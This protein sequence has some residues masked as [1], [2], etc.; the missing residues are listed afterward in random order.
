M[1]LPAVRH[2]LFS[3]LLQFKQNIFPSTKVKSSLN[4]LTFISDGKPQEIKDTTDSFR[5]SLAI[6]E[7]ER[8][9]P[10][11]VNITVVDLLP[12]SNLTEVVDLESL[13]VTL[14]I[15]V[16]TLSGCKS[17]LIYASLNQVPGD[18]DPH[19]TTSLPN[20]QYQFDDDK[21]WKVII[22]LMM[23]S[24]KSQT[25]DNKLH[26]LIIPQGKYVGI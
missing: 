18:A 24:D 19:F 1:V 17:L 11:A 14:V 10:T 6:P 20:E 12:Q 22:D 21:R 4:G 9:S 13:D 26:L 25:S 8:S 7:A 5:I 2:I 16:D 23:F 15:V 3:Q